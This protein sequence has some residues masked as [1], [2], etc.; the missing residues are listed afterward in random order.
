MRGNNN[1]IEYG[2]CLA[3]VSTAKN[4]ETASF[5]FFILCGYPETSSGPSAALEASDAGRVKLVHKGM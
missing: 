2:G 5:D 3:T 4:F 1:R